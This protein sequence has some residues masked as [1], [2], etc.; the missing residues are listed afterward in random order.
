MKIS[1]HSMTD[2][3]T[4]SSTVIYTYSDASEQALREMIDELFKQFG[5]DKTCDE[6][7]NLAIVLENKF[8]Y[9]DDA[10]KEFDNLS[11]QEQKDKLVEIFNSIAKGEITKPKWMKRAEESRS[12]RGYKPSNVLHITAKDPKYDNLAKLI[13]NFLYSTDCESTYDG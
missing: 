12:S 13:T 7:F 1:I 10:P 5:I 8:D 3:I 9:L 11:Y 4:N 2:L 6:V